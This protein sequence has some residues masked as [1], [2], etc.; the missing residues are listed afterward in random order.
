MAFVDMHGHSRKKNVFVYDVQLEDGS[1]GT[2]T[3]DSGAGCNVWPKGLE[4]GG[5]VLKPRKKG[6]SMFAANGTPIN[7]FG[8]RMVTFRG[9]EAP[10]ESVFAR[11]A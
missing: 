11:R 10:K 2:V 8:Q 3:L 6:V 7:Y 5:S 9:I 4:A 1:M